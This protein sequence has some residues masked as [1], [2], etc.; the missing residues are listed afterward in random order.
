MAPAE[1]LA[2][3]LRD[4]GITLA[5]AE[6]AAGGLI[7]AEL[8]RPSGSSAWF[9]GG[10]VAY[11]DASK[12]TLLGIPEQLLVDHGSV[13][14]EAARALAEAARRIFDADFGIGETSIAGPGGATETKPVGLTFVA[15]ASAQE[16]RHHELH[17]TGTREQNR[18]GAV[19]AALALLASLIP[20]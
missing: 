11:D 14:A 12:T 9:R 15:V 6:S 17:L 5:V 18:E 4:A 3:R 19:D 8:T 20:M 13:S 7:A 16:T 10:V 2:T 1:E